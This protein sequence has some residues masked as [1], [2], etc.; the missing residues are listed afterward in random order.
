LILIRWLALVLA[1]VLV[2]CTSGKAASPPAP[3]TTAST[4]AGPS[5]TTST[6]AATT[7]PATTTTAQPGGPYSAFPT[8]DAAATSLVAAWDRGDRARAARAA[9]P[10]VISALFAV[11][12]PAAAPQNRGCNA[13]LGGMATC[14]Y[15][16]GN[17]A[18]QLQ[19]RDVPPLGWQVVQASFVS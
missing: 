9:I 11:V 13:G 16:V 5:D 19:L 12:P 18:L 7:V 6:S 10:R 2:G 14:F 17:L 1:L 8:P 4:A 3:S 15:R